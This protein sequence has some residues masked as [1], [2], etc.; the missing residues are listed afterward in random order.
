MKTQATATM[1]VAETKKIDVATDPADATDSA[2]VLAAA[3][4]TSSDEAIAT[5]A[6]DGTITAVAAGKATITVT[7]NALTANTALTVNAADAA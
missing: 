2:A 6:T 1:K 7:S 5:V 3:T 4:W